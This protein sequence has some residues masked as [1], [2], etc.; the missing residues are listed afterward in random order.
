MIIWGGFSSVGFLN[1]GAR[2]NTALELW[3]TVSI[4]G[5]P[6][7]RSGHLG[8]WTGQKLVVWGGRNGGG[9]LNDG[10]VYD[11]ASDQWTPLNVPNPPAARAGATAVWAGDRMIVWGGTGAGGVINSGAQLRFD[12]NGDAIA[13]VPTS[14]VS[15]PEG[16]VAH[17]A[18]WAG[19][20]MV[21]WGGEGD[22]T[23]LRD[24]AAFDP[25]ANSWAA[26]ESDGAPTARRGHV[27]IWLGQE[28]DSV[29]VVGGDTASGAT[30]SG[31]AYD[32]GEQTWRAL[33]LGG[34]PAP[35]SGASA[36]WTG[37]DLIV[38]GGKSNGNAVGVP[39][40][41]SPQPDWYF[42]RKP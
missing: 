35:R 37:S 22:T 21:V 4:A 25:Q 11:P 23:L 20:T 13:W 24:G 9:L 15:A 10:G 5:A 14:S 39:Q 26:L 8:V 3:K 32:L 2:F 40:R 7:Q 19:D 17:S 12:S 30:A 36:V 18:V 42:Y 1:T 16:R 41:L 28:Q 33:T 29:V 34:D 6:S 27:S 38:F 31:A